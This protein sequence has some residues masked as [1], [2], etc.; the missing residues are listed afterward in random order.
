MP[1][2]EKLRIP[3]WIQADTTSDIIE[4][5]G[6]CD[7]SIMAYAAA[8]Y[9]RVIKKGSVHTQILTAKTR[10]APTKQISLP[11]LELCGAHLLGK[12]M[13]H[14]KE[15]RS[16]YLK[17]ALRIPDENTFG[18]CDSAIMIAWIRGHPSRWK[19]FVANRVVQ[20]Q[21]Q[22][23]PAEW[24]YVNTKDKPADMASRGCQP[25]ELLTNKMWWTGPEWLSHKKESWPE[26]PKF[27]ETKEEEKSKETF[28]GV[29]TSS[30]D[31]TIL[32]KFSTL[33]RLIRITAQ[34]IRFGKRCKKI[35]HNTGFLTTTE[36]GEA[37][38]VWIKNVQQ[39]GCTSRNL[40]WWH[41]I[42]NGQITSKIL[43]IG[44]ISI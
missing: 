16:I 42:N 9:V 10:V 1:Q 32:Q 22:I 21:A 30:M 41:P 14:V 17:E 11:R 24:Y 5:H 27:N 34:C 19:T 44:W 43:D 26:Q 13:T 39:A 33:N 15:A 37:L 2:I 20:I 38:N 36:L 31:D 12:L 3:R 18:W 28:V 8:I 25:N 6:F 35:Q 4:L 7:A 40:A 23:Q 29:T